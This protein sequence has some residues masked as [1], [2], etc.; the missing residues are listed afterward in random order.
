MGRIPR[1][2]AGGLAYHVIN[3]AAGRRTIFRHDGDFTAF[4]HV[5]AQALARFAP[6]IQLLAYC[7]MGNHWHLVLHTQED[8]VLSPFMKWLTLTHTQR[9]QVAHRRVGEGPVY[10]GRFKAFPIEADRHLLTVC[11][12]VERNPARASRVERAEDWRWS[13]LWRSLNPLNP[14]PRTPPLV[15]SDWPV[16]GGRPQHWLRT[17]NTPMSEAELK[18]LQTATRRSQPFGNDRWA[19]R[20]TTRYHLVS[21]FRLP[22]RPRKGPGMETPP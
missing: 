18:A 8:G 7:V 13:S 15:L 21:T 1:V 17:V 12:Y 9:W 5:L 11:R 22:G 19:H 4:E 14:E 16:P 6:R 10:Q 2:D 3:R 20:L